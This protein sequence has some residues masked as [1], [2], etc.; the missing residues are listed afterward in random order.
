M[1]YDKTTLVSHDG[2]LIG[3]DNPITIF[4]SFF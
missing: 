3:P 2:Q 1:K 4:P